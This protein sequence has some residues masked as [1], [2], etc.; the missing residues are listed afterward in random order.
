MHLCYLLNAD[1]APYPSSRLVPKT[2]LQGRIVLIAQ[3]T[4]GRGKVVTCHDHA[5]D[6]ELDPSPISQALTCW[7]TASPALQFF[8]SD[9]LHVSTRF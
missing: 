3:M 2:A 9:K 6:A 5:D 7:E 8:T 1:V 4:K